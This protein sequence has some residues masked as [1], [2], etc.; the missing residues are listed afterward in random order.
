[1][2]GRSSTL[3]LLT[4]LVL[5]L[6]SFPWGELNAQD[7]LD[8]HTPLF[9]EYHIRQD[10]GRVFS[11]R[12]GSLED[13]TLTL[14]DERGFDIPLPM[15]R[16]DQILFPGEE[17]E[18]TARSLVEAEN[19]PEARRALHALVEQR[20]P[21]QEIL[22]P[23][24]WEPFYALIKV[25]RAQEDH[26]RAA[27]LIEEVKPF[28]EDPERRDFLR[29]NA[30]LTTFALGPREEALQIAR[31]QIAEE[32]RYGSSALGFYL[33]TRDHLENE[34]FEQA[35]WLALQP[36]V[37]TTP[38][39]QA[40]RP[41]LYALAIE[42]ALRLE[43]SSQTLVLLVEMQEQD[44]SWPSGE[45]YRRTQEEALAVLQQWEEA[46]RQREEAAAAAED[47]EENAGPEETLAEEQSPPLE[48]LNLPLETVRRLLH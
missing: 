19:W 25:Y 22:Q 4:L 26:R 34:Q 35:L 36:L 15:A 27:A 3:L 20:R 28:N 29:E 32:G 31:E 48:D 46:R 18:E 8:Y 16:I 39:P 13:G 6:G 44:Y 21:F 24:Q 33:I 23:E 47:Q 7:S 2:P 10:N 5:S 12:F 37:F 30:L 41:E 11:G 9:G 14:R 45:S 43:D 40:Y 1:M 42:A 17:V 38:F